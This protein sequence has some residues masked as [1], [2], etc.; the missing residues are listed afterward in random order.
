MT[1]AVQAPTAQ[2]VAENVATPAEIVARPT[3]TLTKLEP[4]TGKITKNRVRLRLQPHLDGTILKELSKEA[5]VIVNGAEDEFYAVQP[6]PEA[7]GY[8]FRTYILDGEVVGN[9]INVRLE[10]DTNAPIV[11]QLNNGDKISGTVSS[12]NNRWLEIDLPDSAHFYVAKEFVH[13]IG[14][15]QTYYTIEKK[16]AE[17]STQLAAL[18][19]S[20]TEELQK[21]FREIQLQ[22]ITSELNDIISQNKEEVLLVEK[23]EFLVKKMQETYLEKSIAYKDVEATPA[24][25]EEATPLAV[26]EENTPSVP[27]VVV[28]KPLLNDFEKELFQRALGTG[29]VTNIDQFYAQEQK[30]ATRL[31]GIIKPNT[32]PVKN[33]P[34]DYLLVNPKTNLPLAYL[35]STRV[36]L[37]TLVGK[38]MSLSLSPRPNNNFAYPAYFVLKAE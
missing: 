17:L 10:P 1:A 25:L 4:F 23:A 37:S 35:Y 18:E 21:P 11:C 26:H 16:R 5:L 15:A 31:C 3:T 8:V 20:L 30:K 33:L 28:A 12:T 22:R 38:E 2:P 36:D 9:H 24:L 6:A 27:V 14:D 7:K 19:L 32:R 29:S 13:R 34:G